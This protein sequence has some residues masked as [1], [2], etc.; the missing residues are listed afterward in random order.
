ML[1]LRLC[2]SCLVVADDGACHHCPLVHPIGIGKQS[3]VGDDGGLELLIHGCLSHVDKVGS[4][5]PSYKSIS[6]PLRVRRAGRVG[7][8]QPAH[9]LL[10][11]VSSIVGKGAITP[12][13]STVWHG[14]C[15]AGRIAPTLLA[16]SSVSRPLIS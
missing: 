1:Y 15:G 16:G 12:P 3:S 14:T 9:A 4:R 8:K 2:R 7:V 10:P 13:E 5:S 6:N 11:A